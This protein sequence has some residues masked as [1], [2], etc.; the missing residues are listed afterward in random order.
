MKGVIKIVRKYSVTLVITGFV[1]LWF[2]MSGF[3]KQ[4]SYFT[5][6]R[7]LQNSVFHKS[8][9][10]STLVNETLPPRRIENYLGE[11]GIDTANMNKPEDFYEE[12]VSHQAFPIEQKAKN[13]AL[14]RKPVKYSHLLL[15]AQNN[16]KVD[17]KLGYLA[18]RKRKASI[19]DRKVI[20]EHVIDGNELNTVIQEAR[21]TI[22]QLLQ[23]ESLTSSIPVLL[24][25]YMRSGSS[26]L[27]DITQQAKDS[28]Y[29]YEPFQTIINQGYYTNGLVCFYDDTCRSPRKDYESHHIML[30]NILQ[31]YACDFENLH[32]KVYHNVYRR[33]K[34]LCGQKFRPEKIRPRR[35]RDVN[36]ETKNTTKS[37]CQKLQAEECKNSKYRIIK[38]IRISMDLVQSL[39]D[40]IP[41]LKV[42]HLVRDPRAIT[43]SRTHSG[44]MRLSKNTEPHSKSLC[45]EMYL[46]LKT[47]QIMT[48]K[49]PQSITIVIYEALAENPVDAA[50][51]IYKYLNIKFDRK[52]EN[53]VYHSA[54]AKRSN[55]FFGTQR[56][57]S[58]VA[59]A[60]WRFETKIEK[61]KMIQIHCKDVM[62]LLGYVPFN[63]KEELRNLDIPARQ[64]IA[65]PGYT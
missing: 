36:F 10:H 63:S 11:S 45:K 22:Q 13:T 33:K 39:M 30:K 32:P 38:T 44:N 15:R 29:V 50:K 34:Y 9:G 53:W 48:R 43:N 37:E 18:S 17:K 52:I 64:R 56:L 61:V 27:G 65:L 4:Y 41:Q 20:K 1:C 16:T 25:T 62:D 59:S 49:Y 2:V 19:S 60:H 58:T 3:R 35:K 51:Y 8:A 26:W 21:E 31:I 42:V 23:H 6:S 28:F 5:N 46:D 12:S 24:V 55:G 40:F 7:A 57:N 14:K 47:T 54:Y